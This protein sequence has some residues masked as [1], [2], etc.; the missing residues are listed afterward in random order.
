MIK[1]NALNKLTKINWQRPTPKDIQWLMEIERLVEHAHIKS[2][3]KRQEQITD[4]QNR[5]GYV[6][7]LASERNLPQTCQ[8]CLSSNKLTVLRHSDKC[9]LNCKFCYYYGEPEQYYP[10]GMIQLGDR[11]Q[12][13]EDIPLM[14][15]DQGEKLIRW[16]SYEPLMNMKTMLPTMKWFSENGYYQSLNTNGTL[17]SKKVLKQLADAGLNDLRF[18]PAATLCHDEVLENMKNAKGMFDEIGIESPM[19]HQFKQALV[20]NIDVI[21]DVVDYISFQELQLMPNNIGKFYGPHYRYHQGHVTTLS[22]RTLV[23]D[24]FELAVEN[25]W[26]TKYDVLFLDCSSELKFYRGVKRGQYFADVSNFPSRVKLSLNWYN[27]AI[28]NYWK[29]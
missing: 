26:H 16:V 5:D 21:L 25:D 20:D 2:I 17:A 13:P 14:F 6:F 15:K 4:L 9:N 23:Y 29:N 1:G 28:Q 10:K 11:W 18:N 7:Y 3:R 19:F 24:F 22:S 8:A 12:Y 27:W